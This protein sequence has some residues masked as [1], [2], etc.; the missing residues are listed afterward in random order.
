MN[1]WFGL[2]FDRGRVPSRLAA[3]LAVVASHLFVEYNELEFEQ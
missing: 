1:Y 2:K 3:V